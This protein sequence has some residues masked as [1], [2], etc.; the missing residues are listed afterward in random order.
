MPNPDSHRHVEASTGRLQQLAGRVADACGFLYVPP[1]RLRRGAGGDWSPE[2]KA[3]RVGSKDVATGGQRLWY[4]LA[5]ELAH[6]QAE[7]G[8]GHSAAFWR[9]L[10]GGL[11]NAGH[12]EFLRLDIGYREGALRVAR[13]YGLL[14]LP[15]RR[16]FLFK[17]GDSVVDDE[18]RRWTIK[19]RFR[20]GGGP[21]YRLDSPGWTWTV[22]EETLASLSR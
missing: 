4:T 17:I 14:D 15:P 8:K 6:A 5:H 7:S 21:V 22:P 11:G 3:I 20:R 9:T 2:R 10:A 19:R 18:D 12:L 16:V 13:E 1:V